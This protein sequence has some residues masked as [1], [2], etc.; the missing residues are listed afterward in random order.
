MLA[1]DVNNIL[2][3]WPKYIIGMLVYVTYM[4]YD[5]A[6]TVSECYQTKELF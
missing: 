2:K 5:I 3:H 6:Y 1:S 4:I